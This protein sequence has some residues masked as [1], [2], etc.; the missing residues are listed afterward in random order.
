MTWTVP[1]KIINPAKKPV[2][3][4]C[5]DCNVN[6]TDQSTYEDGRCLDCQMALENPKHLY[7]DGKLA[8]WTCKKK[9]N[10]TYG[11]DKG[12]CL[13]CHQVTKMKNG[14]I[15]NRPKIDCP[16]FTDQWLVGGSA[17]APYVITHKSGTWQCS[18]P[19]WTKHTPRTDCKHIVN[20]KKYEGILVE[21]HAGHP[22]LLMPSSK[23]IKPTAPAKTENPFADKGR[24]FR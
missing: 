14:E 7:L 18:C 22:L 12:V 5:P 11:V 19:D 24:R 20:V 1:I 23:F 3:R 4:R 8:C 15:R 13:D 9:V 2:V 21:N 10:E 17:K 6:V 16:M